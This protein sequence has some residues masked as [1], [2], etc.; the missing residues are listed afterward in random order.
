MI[1]LSPK[2]RHRDLD[3][4]LHFPWHL[5]QSDDRDLELTALPA[6]SPADQSSVGTVADA[7]D[8]SAAV[9]VNEVVRAVCRRWRRRWS[10]TGGAGTCHI[11]NIP[12]SHLHVSFSRRR[13]LPP[14]ATCWKTL[15]A[16]SG[17]RPVSRHVPY[18]AGMLQRWYVTIDRQTDRQ[19][20]R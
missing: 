4:T 17:L 13:L 6:I 18:D 20:D 10:C 7:G 16:Q 12:S 15:Q 1:W 19:T 2:Q 9:A 3:V 11:T 8:L 14:K 5:G